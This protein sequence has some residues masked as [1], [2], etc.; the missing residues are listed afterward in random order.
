M[1]LLFNLLFV[2][3]ITATAQAQVKTAAP[4]KTASTDKFSYP[5]AVKKPR[6]NIAVL[7]P[8]YLDSFKLADD[9][10]N[11][12]SFAA[13][14]IDF[15][16]GAQLAA[17]TL[18]KMGTK[19]SIHVLDSKGKFMNLENLIAGGSLDSADCII[20]NI[21]G[22]DL[23]I[24]AD[25]AKSK[26][27]NF[28]SAVSPNDANQFHNPYFTLLQPRLSTHIQRLRKLID[29]KYS[30]K[31]II[32]IHKD[33]E[34]ENN[35]FLYYKNDVTT[36]TNKLKEIV[37]P[38]DDLDMDKILPLLDKGGDNLIVLAN[39]NAKTAL[40]NLESLHAL[41]AEGYPLVVFGMPT[42]EN[43]RP[44]RIPGELDGMEVY[45]T[46]PVLQDKITQ[47]YKYISKVYKNKMK[48]TS[49]PD[50]AYKG[51]EAVFYIANMLEKHG[52]PFNENISDNEPSFV[53]PYRISVVKEN[54]K[55]KYYENKFL[56]VVHYSNG[57]LTYE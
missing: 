39:L 56:Y 3:A 27:I 54:N 16:V 33:N 42:W 23:K 9:P 57:I 36:S 55:L 41:T 43:I 29:L 20:G 51:F 5:K 25:F 17:D 4:Q 15:Y 44:L 50:I 6:Y 2:L 1:K 10:N 34:A 21:G 30:N 38:T 52:V 46:S 13:P 22:N 53:T 47:P 8:M 40:Q 11:I 48:T 31:N 26:K 19:V 49:V 24:A 18:D 35:A 37:Q 28:I 32:F 12:P 14:G 45:F 7:T